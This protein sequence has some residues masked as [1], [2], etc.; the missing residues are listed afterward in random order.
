MINKI[1]IASLLFLFSFNCFSEELKKNN[2]NIHYESVNIEDKS[3]LFEEPDNINYEVFYFF[4]YSCPH[5]YDFKDFIEKWK[6]MKKP[7]V[8]LYFIPVDF[9]EGWE[10]T[11]K[12][13]IINEQLNI[14]D[15]SNILFNKIHKKN[16]KIYTKEDLD[17]FFISE[18]KIDSEKYN[19]IYNSMDTKIKLKKYQQITDYL[20]IMG[21][22]NIVLLTKKKEVYKVSPEISGGFFNTILSLEYL[23]YKDK[24]SNK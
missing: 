21:T 9:R 14:P 2:Y 12:A 23:M 19:A 10:E 17:N 11:A 1:F 6:E 16:E 5:C 4:S 22:P 7:D 3:F 13:Y 8:A 24:K 18:L 20:Q 15:F